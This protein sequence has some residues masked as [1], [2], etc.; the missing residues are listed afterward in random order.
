MTIAVLEACKLMNLKATK[1]A[2]Y[3]KYL[4]QCE[5]LDEELR[6]RSKRNFQLRGRFDKLRGRLC[7]LC[8]APEVRKKLTFGRKEKPLLSFCGGCIPFLRNNLHACAIQVLKCDDDE[9]A[10][11]ALQH[12]VTPTEIL[13]PCDKNP[14][15]VL[16]FREF[17]KDPR[18]EQ[19]S[20][21][22]HQVF[23]T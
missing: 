20:A 2:S 14:A 5:R 1:Q 4:Q 12:Q 7:E 11:Q 18:Q 23:G 3:A 8:R 16:I 10:Q 17:K 9:A 6:D 22:Q 15:G 19:P 21:V 13:L